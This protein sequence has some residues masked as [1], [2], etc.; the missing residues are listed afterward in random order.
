MHQPIVVKAGSETPDAFNGTSFPIPECLDLLRSRCQVIVTED[1]DQATLIDAVAGASILMYTYGQ[2]SREILEAGQPTLKTII[3]MGTGID[4]VDFSAAKEL[5]V[6]IVNC[7][8]YAR[9]A[10]AETA[11]L[12]LINC[13]KKFVAIH[14]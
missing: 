3:K 8:D 2:I 11:F 13:F 5:G 9:F 14:F 12:L 10:V 7:P 4:S 1:E 6:R